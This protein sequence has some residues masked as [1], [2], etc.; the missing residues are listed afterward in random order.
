[1]LQETGYCWLDMNI[2]EQVFSP[3]RFKAQNS[4]ET[5]RDHIKI[6]V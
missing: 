5:L 4:L 3:N 2:H 1:M 6:Y